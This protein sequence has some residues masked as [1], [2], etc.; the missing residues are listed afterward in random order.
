MVHIIPKQVSTLNFRTRFLIS[1]AL[2]FLKPKWEISSKSKATH[3]FL[4]PLAINGLICPLFAGVA[5]AQASLEG[6]TL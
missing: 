2:S 4:I 3:P 5:I 6:K 1:N